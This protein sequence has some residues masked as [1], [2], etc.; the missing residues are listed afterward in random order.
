MACRLLKTPGAL[1]RIGAKPLQLK[2]LKV[3]LLPPQPPPPPLEPASSDRRGAA[4]SSAAAA[5]EEGVSPAPP[6]SIKS[7][8]APL[9][10]PPSMV[11]PTPSSSHECWNTY[12]SPFLNPEEQ[13]KEIKRMKSILTTYGSTTRGVDKGTIRRIPPGGSDWQVITV[14]VRAL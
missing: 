12:I 10:S 6:P 13:H 1:E 14:K 3:A 11:A 4:A 5:Q 2:R 7:S 8:N 9:G